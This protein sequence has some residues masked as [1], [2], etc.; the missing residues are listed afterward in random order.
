MTQIQKRADAL[1]ALRGLAIL[2]M[3]LSGTIPF[4]ASISLPAWMYHAQVPP[5]H[6]IFNPNL[7]GL[8][9]VDL[10]FPFFLF[11]MG[12]AFPFSLSKKL[13]SGIP[14]W[15]IV[16]QV[17]LRG[18]TLAAFAI[19]I[20]HIRPYV[21]NPNTTNFDWFIGL[22]GFALLF[23]ILLRL[24]PTVKPIIR[25]SVKTAGIIAAV[26]L[27]SFLKYPDGS[28]FSLYRSDIIIL[29]LANVAV[30]GSLIWLFTKDNILLRLGFLGILIALR[31]TQ[32]VDGSWNA[33]LWNFSPF[34]W[35]YKL[36]YC[37]YLF[38]VL[39]GTIVGD[40]I[41]KWMKSEKSVANDKPNLSSTTM[42]YSLVL[43]IVFVLV[44]LIG[45]YS[46]ELVFTAVA[47]VLLCL[48]GLTFFKNANNSLEKLYKSLFNWGAYWLILGIFFEA[49]EG[50]IK[51]D[52]PTMSYYFVTTG[53]AI[54]TYIAFSICL[55]YFKKI[56]FFKVIIESGQN[57]MIAY[58]A[59]NNLI[60]PILAITSL[61]VLLNQLMISPWI[62]F[63]K[64]VI[65][66]T[67]VALATSFFTRK[68]L[69]W[70]T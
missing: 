56:K 63:F 8:T 24:P 28:G 32:N 61:D 15:K 55:D 14:K 6:H 42:L 38:I 4:G 9:W 54:F 19:Y 10:V 51:K 49:Y 37:Q 2:L 41:Y 20:Q 57:P 11:A 29:V 12:A 1:D 43:M 40:M 67:L 64:G 25:Y 16:I 44:N 22:I 7:P 27:V 59:G 65:L 70:R 35:L 23:P 48:A 66:T 68:K 5:P 69:F 39:P 31:L 18:L 30:F 53:L 17:I 34:P 47:D 60:L 46:R 21:I 13:N 58:M 62:G 3:I 45:L 52:H 36:Y 33:W 50:G 26:I